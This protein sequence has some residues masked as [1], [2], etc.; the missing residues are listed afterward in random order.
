MAEKYEPGGAGG[1]GKRGSSAHAGAGSHREGLKAQME[2]QR[3]KHEAYVNET[4]AA[5]DQDGNG[6][7]DRE[8]IRTLLK[9]ISG[10]DPT[11]AGLDVV[12]EAAGGKEAED[13]GGITREMLLRALKK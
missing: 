5:L 2:A 6:R 10:K 8:E 12:M 3:H 1:G 9:V 13:A 4:Y 7:L 11:K